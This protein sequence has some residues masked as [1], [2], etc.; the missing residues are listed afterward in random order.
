[1]GCCWSKEETQEEEHR[2]HTVY[3]PLPRTH[4]GLSIISESSHESDIEQ[5]HV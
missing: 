3:V 2:I 5:I 4:Y 1:M